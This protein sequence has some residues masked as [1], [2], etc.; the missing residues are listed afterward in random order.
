MLIK[1][2]YINIDIF[3]AGHGVFKMDIP[4]FVITYGPPGCGKSTIA[5]RIYN[6]YVIIDVDEIVSSLDGFLEESSM[7]CQMISK[8]VDRKIIERQAYYLYQRFR[9]TADRK[10]EELLYSSIAAGKNIVFE[11]TGGSQRAIM[12]LKGIVQHVRVRKYNV[13]VIFPHAPISIMNERIYDRG[14]DTGR[15]PS[16][17]FIKSSYNYA[18]E[19]FP[20]V[21]NICDEVL[22]ND[23]S[24]FVSKT[25][26]QRCG[27]EI[28]FVDLESINK[29]PSSM[30]KYLL[31]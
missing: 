13:K 17:E 2:K 20:E 8:G 31:G 30:I 18:C 27:H 10:S 3:L 25:I 9:D 12:Y 19:N 24:G 16:E 15:L 28:D 11:T 6:E 22:V 29:L 14:K 5:K 21:A 26:Y 4:I 23:S 1:K 7:I